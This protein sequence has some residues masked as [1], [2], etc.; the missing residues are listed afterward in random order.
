MSS[1]NV[2]MWAWGVLA[3]VVAISITTDLIAHRGDHV[4][5]KKRALAW[6]SSGSSS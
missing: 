4:D 1:L 6:R 5:S 2:P 3:G